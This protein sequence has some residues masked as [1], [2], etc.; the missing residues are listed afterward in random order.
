MNEPPVLCDTLSTSIFAQQDYALNTRA[1]L[2]MTKFLAP[3]EVLISNWRMLEID[4]CF[5]LPSTLTFDVS[6]V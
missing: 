4:S 6:W 2:L 5:S 1:N 3:L